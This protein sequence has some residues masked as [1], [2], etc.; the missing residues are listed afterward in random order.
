MELKRVVITGVGIVS[1]LGIGVEETW[2]ALIA[3]KSGAAPIT[4]F[5]ASKFNTQFACEVK[6]FDSNQYFDRK[7]ARKLDRYAQYA[8]VAAKEAIGSR[9][10]R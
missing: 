1:P 8:I 3:G 6:G 7:E 2:S 10:R 5:D 9:S 4:H